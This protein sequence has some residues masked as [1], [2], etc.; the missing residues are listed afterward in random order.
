MKHKF[1]LSLL[2]FSLLCGTTASFY[3]TTNV[4]AASYTVENGTVSCG[5]GEASITIYGNEGQSLAGKQFQLYKLFHVENA[6]DGESVNYS[7]NDTY[8]AALQNVVGEKL[9]KEPSTVTEY[10]VIDYIQGL[11]NFK[12][13]GADAVQTLESRYSD[14]RYFVEILRDEMVRLGCTGDTITVNSVST[15]NSFELVGLDYGYYIVDEITATEG[16]NAASSLCMVSTANPETSINI[17]SDYPTVSKKIQEDDQ[18]EDAGENGWNDIA[19][20]EIG[21]SVPYQYTSNIPNINGYSTYYYAWHDV[22]DDALS[23]QRD[24][25]EIV[26]SDEEKSYTLDVSEFSVV[27]NPDEDTTFVI[28]VNDMK[29]IIDREFNNMDALGHNTYGQVVTL[30]Y[31]AILN[32]LAANDTGRPGFENNVRLEFSNNPDNENEGAD[33]P[34]DETGFTPWDTVVCF[35]YQLD[36]LK[37][38]DKDMPL[39]NAKFRLYSDESCQNEVY[40]KKSDTGYIVM[41]RDSLGGTDHVG[42]ETPS[43][44][45]V[46]ESAE[47]GTFV[48]YGLDDGI[49]YL[50]E[51]DAPDGYRQILDPIK[52]TVDAVYTTERD[53]YLKGDG[54]TEKALI[55]LN[56]TADIKLFLD[57]KY[58]ESSREL[59]TDVEN[60]AAN[61]TI[62]NHVGSKLPITGSVGTIALI[63]LGAG[64]MVVGLKKEKS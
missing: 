17:K 57:G 54:T 5:T 28:T 1:L 18:L 46:M 37:T 61:L 21:Q 32:D 9:S 36:V 12:V 50:K 49:Y 2:A 59:V 58:E 16:T 7:F 63:V 20:F 64:A 45:V 19:D 44:A 27:E 40:V 3:G 56:V 11:N 60:G 55:D 51:V 15:Y 38:N 42:G 29:A 62:I 8:K 22:M 24:S 52:L 39:A 47:D 14:F 10:D 53:S 43:D 13:E 31:T 25:V 48:I 26:I 35:T 6:V 41:N 23:F 34:D 4:Y 30:N 33:K